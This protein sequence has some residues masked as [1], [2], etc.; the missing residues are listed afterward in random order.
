MLLKIENLNFGWDETLLLKG[1]SAQLGSGQIVQLMGPNGAGKTTLLHLIAGLI[2]HF[3]RGAMLTGDILI[4]G[5]SILTAPPKSFF[6]KIAYVPSMHLDLFLLTESLHQ[7]LELTSGILRADCAWREQ[8]IAEFAAFFPEIKEIWHIPFKTAPHQQ[9]IL[10]LSLIYYVQ[11]AQLFL[12][13]EIFPSFS[14][15]LKSKWLEFFQFLGQN[16]STVIFVDHQRATNYFGKWLLNEKH[17]T[18]L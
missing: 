5:R 1:I 11:Q 18:C 8:R 4:Q 14:E 7:E 12:F 9:K 10:A 3:H 13:D 15:P 16:H 17:L 6:P 2:P